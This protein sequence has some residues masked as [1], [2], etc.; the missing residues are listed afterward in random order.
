MKKNKHKQIEYTWLDK[1][2]KRIP[3]GMFFFLVLLFVAV[4]LI[5]HE[6]VLHSYT[7][8]PVCIPWMYAYI[9]MAI[10]LVLLALVKKYLCK[11]AD[12]LI[13]ICGT[14]LLKIVF[15][16]IIVPA[17]ILLPNRY[18]PI[19]PEI[20]YYGVVIDQTSIKSSKSSATNSNYVKIKLNGENTSFW[21]DINN[22]TEPIGKRSIFY[23]RRG[24]FGMRY[25]H[26]ID[27]L[28]E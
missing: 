23:V 25:A 27:F 7:L 16:I 26:K 1:L 8:L 21:C 22:D 11:S 4:L 14:Y 24:I 2:Y 15:V 19:G 20:E 6:L 9:A 13:D 10:L 12:K 5:I 17:I 18:I 28:V 3:S